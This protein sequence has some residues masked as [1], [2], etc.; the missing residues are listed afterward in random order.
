MTAQGERFAAK[1]GRELECSVP[2]RD[3]QARH[4]RRL[5]P[6][7]SLSVEL[8]ETNTRRAQ[9]HRVSIWTSVTREQCDELVAA[10][11]ADQRGT[12][13]QRVTLPAVRVGG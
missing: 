6:L 1:I 5:R 13:V 7:E 4:R 2:E 8:Y 11:A 10:G 9:H 3:R 12:Q